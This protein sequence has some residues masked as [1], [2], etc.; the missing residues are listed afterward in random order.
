M[1]VCVVFLA[2]SNL[3]FPRIRE[4]ASALAQV[5]ASGV[6]VCFMCSRILYIQSVATVCDFC[7][8]LCVP[9]CQSD[10]CENDN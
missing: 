9:E 10:K 5:V 6:L 3:C 2:L 7:C 8:C 1:S 4:L